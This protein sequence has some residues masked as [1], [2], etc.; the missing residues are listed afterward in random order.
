MKIEIPRIVRRLDL[1]DYAGEMKEAH[2]FMWVNPPRAKRAEIYLISKRIDWV[3]EAAQLLSPTAPPPVAP[4]P[5]MEPNPFIGLSRE[6]L[7][8]KALEVHAQLCAWWAEMW[9][10]GEPELR[11]TAEEVAEFFA[12]AADTDPKLISFI[13]SGCLHLMA[14]HAERAQKN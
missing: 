9:S 11:W 6:E 12:G 8:A 3:A 7:E 10:Q 4:Q 1:G 14:E 5:D 2:I 13:R